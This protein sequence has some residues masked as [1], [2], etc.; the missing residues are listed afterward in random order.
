MLRRYNKRMEEARSRLG[1]KCVRCGRIDGLQ[2]DHI[3]P[4]NKS[5]TIAKLWSI[6]KELF[7]IEVNKCQLLCEPCHDAKT[8]IDKGQVSGKVTH[9]TLSSYRY[10][11]CDLCRKAKRDYGRL[12][13]VRERR[14]ERR[15]LKK[16]LGP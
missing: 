14:N 11:K 8:L 15:R 1:G 6:R 5:F 4:K 2:L 12:P 7:D 16:I 13:W 9:G 3:D 10:C